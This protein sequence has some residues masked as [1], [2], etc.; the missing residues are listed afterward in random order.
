[1]IRFGR[2]ALLVD[3]GEQIVAPPPA[4]SSWKMSMLFGERIHSFQRDNVRVTEMPQN[5]VLQIPSGAIRVMLDSTRRGSFASAVH[6][7]ARA[8]AR[9][10]GS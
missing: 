8:E 10:S 4:T 2:L 3:G 6:V 7:A 9:E 1:M 5:V